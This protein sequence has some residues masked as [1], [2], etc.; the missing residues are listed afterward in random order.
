VT[1]FYKNKV[2]YFTYGR[3]FVCLIVALKSV[4]HSQSSVNWLRAMQFLLR[5]M[6][7]NEEF[8]SPRIADELRAMQSKLISIE[9][10]FNTKLR[11]VA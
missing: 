1:S 11:Y 9:N 5:A 2:G 3:I 7:H 8:F 4:A 10:I 6:L